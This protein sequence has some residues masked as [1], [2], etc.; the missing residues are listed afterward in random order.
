MQKPISVSRGRWLNGRT[1]N[2]L[3]GAAFWLALWFCLLF[4]LRQVPGALGNVLCRGMQVF[5]GMALVAVGIPLAWRLVRQQ[6][7]GACAT[8]WC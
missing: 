4:A 7:C 1:S 5:V 8:S 2:R 6:C 3:A